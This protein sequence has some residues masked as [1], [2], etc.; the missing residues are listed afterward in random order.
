M[1]EKNT[2]HKDDRER[3]TTILTVD[4]TVICRICSVTTNIALRWYN[5]W[6]TA[7]KKY[8][9]HFRVTLY[10]GDVDDPKRVEEMVSEYDGD[11][12]IDLTPAPVDPSKFPKEWLR[13]VYE[14]SEKLHPT[15]PERPASVAKVV[16]I[17]PKATKK[18]PS[19]QATSKKTTPSKSTKTTTTSKA[20]TPKKATVKATKATA[21]K[22]TAKTT[23]KKETAKKTTPKATTKKA[24]TTAKKKVIKKS[25]K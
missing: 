13:P 25:Q 9:G 3:F 16:T 18:S 11:G 10:S 17:M 4:G 1:I 14:P 12:T 22:A 5:E 19:K 24:T 7:Y 15:E 8:N 21:K 20:A 6:S 23:V 2:Y